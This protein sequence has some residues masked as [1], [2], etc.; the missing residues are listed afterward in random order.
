MRLENQ[1]WLNDAEF[2]SYVGHFMEMPEVKKLD[3][4]P[5]HYTS[6]R[7]VHSLWV[8]YI[9][10]KLAKRLGWNQK[11]A[12]RAGLFHD[13]FYYDWRDTKFE[14]SHAYIHPRIAYRNASK[15]TSLSEL[16]KD[17]II[18]HMWGATLNPPRYK[19]SW[20]LTFVDD[21]VAMKE[22]AQTARFKWANRKRLRQRLASILN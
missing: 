12:A 13:M 3:A 4:I 11:A 6:T 20:L 15:L 5:H 19:E 18:K 1:P 14:K 17:M 8:S 10:Y 9:S 21:Y 7:M 2:M 16:E 22:G